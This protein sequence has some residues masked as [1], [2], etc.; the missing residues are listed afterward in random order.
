M[1]SIDNSKE[2]QG[3]INDYHSSGLSAKAWCKLNKKNINALHCWNKKLKK[4]K[5]NDEAKQNWV[6]VQTSSITLSPTITVKVGNVEVS[7]SEGFNK[8]L[9][10]EVV[11]LKRI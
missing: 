2:W 10:S 1:K 3:L 7:V 9:F 6:S 4:T 5:S 11:H 8:E